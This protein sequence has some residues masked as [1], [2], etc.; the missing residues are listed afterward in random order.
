MANFGRVVTRHTR[1]PEVIIPLNPYAASVPTD[2]ATRLLSAT[3]RLGDLSPEWICKHYGVSGGSRPSLG[4]SGTAAERP[5]IDS[6]Q[7]AT[8]FLGP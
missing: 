3:F 4:A 8:E 1:S 6:H 7:G 5:Q 2:A